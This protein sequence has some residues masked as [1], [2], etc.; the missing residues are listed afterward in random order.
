MTR[1]LARER[2]YYP[3]LEAE[4]K[5]RELPYYHPWRSDHSVSGY[6]DFTIVAGDWLMFAELKMPG[7]APTQAQWDWL[8]RLR[9]PW[10]ASA[11]VGTD[12]LDE[13][14]RLIDAMKAR[15]LEGATGLQGFPGVLILGG[16]RVPRGFAGG[17][18]AGRALR[19]GSSAAGSTA[20]EPR[21]R[22]PCTRRASP[23]S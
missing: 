9:G 3:L 18:V 16:V 1:P 19:A 2:D 12:A 4:L 23:G 22:R 7:K 6:P 17:L 11:A 15:R 5:V 10:R 21:P 14:V 20:T 13:L 8:H